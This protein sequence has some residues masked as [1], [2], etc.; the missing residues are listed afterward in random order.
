MPDHPHDPQDRVEDDDA[1]PEIVPVDGDEHAD[2]GHESGA[3]ALGDVG[4]EHD[5]H[6]AHGH[7]DED[8]DDEEYEGG[9]G[10]GRWLSVI[11]SLVT[12]GAL[13]LSW[14]Q[15]TRPNGFTDDA[16]GFQTFT[17]L[18][19]LIIGGALVT[20]VT[21]ALARTRPLALLR[22]AIG[23]AV[24][25]LVL[26]RVISPPDLST[27]TVA[28]QLGVYVALLGALAMVFGGLLDLGGDHDEDE[29][30]DAEHRGDLDG[31]GASA[32]ELGA[33]SEEHDHDV[34]D[35]E[36]VDDD[37]VGADRPTALEDR[38]RR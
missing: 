20:L 24:A 26:R 7:D 4:D 2:L 36:V 6:A 12:I 35:A 14:Y 38:D 25:L 16:T 32:G 9:G 8:E 10:G 21:S 23:A 27:S 13:F 37:H 1:L 22:L 34:L 19:W 29:L 17:K 28:S 11:G 5:H 30:D 3:V 33:G 15:V 31:P 18:R